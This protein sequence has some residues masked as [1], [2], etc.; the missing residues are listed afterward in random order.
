ME[1]LIPIPVEQVAR[2]IEQLDRQI[3]VHVVSARQRRGEGTKVVRLIVS[4]PGG[5]EARAFIYK[6]EGGDG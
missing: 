2:I 6:G 3:P 4:F 1:I 5:G